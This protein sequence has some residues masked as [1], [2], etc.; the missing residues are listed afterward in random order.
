MHHFPNDA[1]LL[2]FS[3]SIKNLKALVKVKYLIARLNANKNDL[4]VQNIVNNNDNETSS[5]IFPKHC[6]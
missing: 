5:I 2:H 1:S 3:R 4:N 6:Q